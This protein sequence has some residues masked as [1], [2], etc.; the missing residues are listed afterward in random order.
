MKWRQKKKQQF[1]ELIEKK[2]ILEK[3]NLELQEKVRLW[4]NKMSDNKFILV[5]LINKYN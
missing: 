2:E 4:S 3:S 5:F 1:H